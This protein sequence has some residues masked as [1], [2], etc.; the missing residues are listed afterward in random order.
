M[1]NCTIKTSGCLS[2]CVLMDRNW[3]K[4]P[5]NSEEYK[6]GVKYF[7]KVAAENS[8]NI[9]FILCPCM[10]CLNIFE[11]NGVAELYD[12]LIFHGIDKTYTRWT[13]HGEERGEQ[14]S[15]NYNTNHQF[16]NT[17]FIDSKFVDTDNDNSRVEKDNPNVI[18]EELRDHPDMHEK[19]KTDAALP[20]WPGCIKAS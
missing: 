14:S 18:N 7:C 13:Y 9:N 16:V 6:S 5:R 17:E 8:K 10:K 4:A 3:I 11:V 2:F 1:L 15:S 20:L 12:H 19:L